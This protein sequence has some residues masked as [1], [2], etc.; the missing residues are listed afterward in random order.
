[1]SSIPNS[2]FILVIGGGPAGAY[3]ATCLANEGHSVVVLEAEKFPR[4]HVGESM[5]PSMRHFLRYIDLEDQFE[6]HGFTPKVGSSF[7]FNP[8]KRE[9]YSDFVAENPNN[10]SWN[11]VRSEADELIL[12]KAKEAGASVFDGV[13]VSKVDF[14]DQDGKSTPVSATWR[15]STG[16]TGTIS[17]KWLIDASGRNGVLSKALGTRK[18]N[19]SLR[20]IASWGYWTGAERYQ[21]PD[22]KIGPPLFQALLDESG[23]AWF[24]PLHNGTASIGVVMDEEIMKSKK[25]EMTDKSSQALYMQELSTRAPMI[26]KLL[27]D[28]K[29]T[30]YGTGPIIRSASDYSYSSTSYSGPNYRIIG[31][32]GAFIDPFFSSGV[33]LALSS[34]LSAAATICAVIRGDCPVDEAVKWHDARVGT[35]Y[36]RFLIVVLSA[37]RQIRAQKL[38]ILSDIDEDNFDRAFENFRVVIQGDA[39]VPEQ[40]TEDELLRT[41]DF[42]TQAFEP[43]SL[44]DIRH[45]EQV[46]DGVDVSAEDAEAKL[47]TSEAVIIARKTMGLEDIFHIGRFVS[48]KVNGRCIRLQRGDLSLM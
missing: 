32:A 5:L 9:G 36:T 21:H 27:S 18:I 29:L 22:A 6:A 30:P 40:M 37:Y 23:W 38:P 46:P 47:R 33:H 2:C 26:W 3:A 31:D 8:R 45:G 16:L 41:V 39:D 43:A 17:F 19:Q 12:N 11:V 20:N 25:A 7:K 4:Y 44:E 15:S 10:Y 14:E 48:D 1:M 42:C 13:K 35:S 24:L 34:A 28:A